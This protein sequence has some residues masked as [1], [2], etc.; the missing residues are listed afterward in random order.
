[1][2]DYTV[3]PLLDLLGLA[4]KAKLRKE[5]LVVSQELLPVIR[6]INMWVFQ[7]W[8]L[9]NQRSAF[10]APSTTH[11]CIPAFRWP[12]SVNSAHHT[13]LRASGSRVGRLHDAGLRSSRTVRHSPVSSPFQLP[14]SVVV[15]L[16]SPPSQR[17]RTGTFAPTRRLKMDKIDCATGVRR[18]A[19]GPF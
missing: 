17:R 19:E 12:S 18:P 2:G 5:R 1:M 4:H 9:V 7:G 3:G 6:R 10:V 16:V 11:F 15:F 14:S 8:G 13:T